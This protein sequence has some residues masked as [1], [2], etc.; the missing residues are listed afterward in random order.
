MVR[1][2]QLCLVAPNL[3][4]NVAGTIPAEFG[5]LT[6]LKALYLYDNKLTGS[7][8]TQLGLLSLLETFDASFNQL[9]GAFGFSLAE[10][11]PTTHRSVFSELISRIE[12]PTLPG[13]LPMQL[14]RLT[15]LE[16][17][18]I[19]VN[20]CSGAFGIISLRLSHRVSECAARG[21]PRSAAHRVVPARTTQHA[22]HWHE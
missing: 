2:T 4:V 21:I 8:P 3:S 12:P 16:K 22:W 6:K 7:L 18:C 11:C 15:Q 20:K 10:T 17:F 9:T 13:P 19:N 14:G 5:H 1:Q